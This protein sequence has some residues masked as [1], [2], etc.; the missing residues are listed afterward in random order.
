MKRI[1][2]TRFRLSAH[3]IKVETGRWSRI[4]RDERKCSCSEDAVQDE[5]DVVFICP[6]SKYL[7]EKYEVDSYG[8]LDVLFNDMKASLICDFM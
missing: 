4:P 1:A 8:T 3:R 2:A 7:R 5:N 6:F